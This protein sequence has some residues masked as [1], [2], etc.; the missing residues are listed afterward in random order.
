MNRIALG[1]LLAVA[2]L[3][4]AAC[5][6]GHGDGESREGPG[7]HGGAAHDQ[8]A[9]GGG[10]QDGEESATQYDKSETYDQIRG[11]ARLI[12]AYDADSNAFTGTVE[13]TTDSVLD[14][15]RVEIHLSNG[16]ELGPTEPG[17]LDPGEQRAITLPASE[18]AFSTWNAHPEVG[19]GEANH[20]SDR[21]QSGSEGEDGEHGE[22][23]DSD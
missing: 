3:I 6:G 18:E 23:G 12:L 1:M 21:Q 15:V 19:R 13:N 4:A 22:G 11:G 8:S 17:D 20:V 9:E 14:S 2:T 10:Q 16:I 7:E 5:S